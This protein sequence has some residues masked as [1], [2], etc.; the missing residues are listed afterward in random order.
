MF[1]IRTKRIMLMLMNL[2]KI[3]PHSL[4][5]Q[6]LAK[7][8]KRQI[9]HNSVFAYQRSRRKEKINRPT[10][11]TV[12]LMSKETKLHFKKRTIRK[13]S[14]IQQETKMRKTKIKIFQLSVFV[15]QNKRRLKWLLQTLKQI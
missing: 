9:Y 11:T 2:F 13:L 5:L 10:L 6:K 7:R 1:M 3:R 8:M 12:S 15:Y 14:K 4:N